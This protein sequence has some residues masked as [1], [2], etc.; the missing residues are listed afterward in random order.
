[1]FRGV[2][3]EPSE[4]WFSV[5]FHVSLC[6]SVWKTLCNYS[7]SNIVLIIIYIFNI[8]ECLASLC[9]EHYT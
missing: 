7:L 3:R 5:T 1:M 9:K 6:T 8:C 2:E 4:V